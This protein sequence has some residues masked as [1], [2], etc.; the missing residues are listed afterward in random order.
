MSV[1]NEQVESLTAIAAGLKLGIVDVSKPLLEQAV[2]T[3]IEIIC[4]SDAEIYDLK[5]RINRLTVV[6][7]NK[8]ANGENTM[9]EFMQS[10]YI[11]HHHDFRAACKIA[12]DHEKPSI[13]GSY[14]QHQIDTLDRLYIN[15]KV[16][17]AL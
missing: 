3:A 6:P 16:K 13:E 17:E 7:A 10:D 5:S 11:T 2:L 4:E 1:T 12:R 8:G 9:T 15:Y 14:W